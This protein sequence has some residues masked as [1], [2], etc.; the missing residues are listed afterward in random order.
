MADEEEPPQDEKDRAEFLKNRLKR[1]KM[2][3]GR[4]QGHLGIY[5]DLFILEINAMKIDAALG[6]CSAFAVNRD[7]ESGK[8]E[9]LDVIVK[10]RTKKAIIPAGQVP[11]IRLTSFED[12]K[13][14]SE[15]EASD[16]VARLMDEGLQDALKELEDEGMSGK[17]GE[18]WEFDIANHTAEVPS[19][20]ESLFHSVGPTPANS[21]DQTSQ[22]S[23]IAASE[24]EELPTTSEGSSS[25]DTEEREAR[26]QWQNPDNPGVGSDGSE[27]DASATPDPADSSD[28]TGGTPEWVYRE[29]ATPDPHYDG[30]GNEIPYNT[31]TASSDGPEIRTLA[32][33]TDSASAAS[34]HSSIGI[35]PPSQELS[36][37]SVHDSEAG[38]TQSMMDEA[39]A[40]TEAHVNGKGKEA[41][42]NIG[43]TLSANSEANDEGKGEENIEKNS[44]HAS[45]D[46]YK[47]NGEQKIP[48]FLWD[49]YDTARWGERIGF[50][51]EL[52]DVAGSLR[53]HSLTVV[54]SG[55]RERNPPVPQPDRMPKTLTEAIC[56][57][58][59]LEAKPILTLTLERVD[60]YLRS[61]TISR[62]NLLKHFE[63]GLDGVESLCQG[64]AKIPETPEATAE[65]ERRVGKIGTLKQGDGGLYRALKCAQRK[66]QQY[67]KGYW[68]F[69][70]VK[71]K[72][73]D[74]QV[75][76]WLLFG[77]P[78]EAVDHL[79]LKRNQENVT[80]MLGGGVDGSG[81]AINPF[82]ANFKRTQTL[83]SRGG[84]APMDIWPGGEDWDDG[85]FEDIKAAMAHNGLR[86]GFL[87]ADTQSF[88][89]KPRGFPAAGKN[90]DEKKRKE[91]GP[92]MTEE[93]MKAMRKSMKG[94]NLSDEDIGA[95]LATKVIMDR[96]K[97]DVA[98]RSK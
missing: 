6:N 9:F 14:A 89:T 67:G 64:T 88:P 15:A 40:V 41:S 62:C 47:G 36:A 55:I 96:A 4:L 92:D 98:G 24:D 19:V 77:A 56:S 86:V 34:Q 30:E 29:N 94:K 35:A 54:E 73:T 81:T 85:V 5:S 49:T 32:S 1:V 57:Y 65:R 42:P 28:A 45:Q 63:V 91:A 23:M 78:I 12:E 11:E 71:F 43:E 39:I 50:G 44:L 3:S 48:K 51:R 66:D 69:F 26:E 60:S 31:S 53:N 87:Y 22:G 83:F 46:Q 20:T 82:R 79:D 59:P 84:I 16:A 33:E 76:K 8:S 25:A 61:P 75:G 13:K 38:A 18:L 10:N 27:S 52:L 7:R 72:Q 93:E 58:I 21:A 80:I 70:G 95:L 90:Q 37:L 17:V 97:Q 2:A 68:Y 74:K